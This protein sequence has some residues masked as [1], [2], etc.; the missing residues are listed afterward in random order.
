MQ[1]TNFPIEVLI[2]DDASTDDTADII[3]EYE[4]KYPEIIKPIYQTEN[5]YSKGVDVFQY[6]FSRAQGKYIALC[7]GDDYWTDPY[8]LQ[9]QV[10]F[11]EKNPEYSIC[12]SGYKIN[13]NELMEESIFCHRRKEGFTYNLQDL[14]YNWYCKTLTTVLRKHILN[15]FLRDYMK[16]R[17]CRD[18]HLF[19]YTLMFGKGYY[20]SEIFGV[21]NRHDNG[22][23][24]SISLREKS[25]V[26]YNVYSELYFCTKNK[27]IRFIFF[28]LI[29]QR[30]K[31]HYYD[32]KEFKKLLN[33]LFVMSYLGFKLIIFLFIKHFIRK[34]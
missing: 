21:Y 18:V 1:Q 28:I 8:K 30:L 25:I 31:R 12:S 6:N 29:I 17:Y 13:K 11:L 3:R 26:N 14:K 19:Y 23:F 27:H 5:Q 32:K 4:R 34:Y 24:S 2:H 16:Y 7:E 22:I 33:E 15:S 20:F 9:K 10:D